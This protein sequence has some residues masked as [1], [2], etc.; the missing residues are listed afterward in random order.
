MTLFMF[1]DF[2]RH[3]VLFPD[4][5]QSGGDDVPKLTAHIPDERQQ[6]YKKILYLIY[7]FQCTYS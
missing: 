1:P 3:L 7:Y 5:G 6:A 4:E 2:I